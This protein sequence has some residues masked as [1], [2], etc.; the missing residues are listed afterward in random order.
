MDNSRRRTYLNKFIK[1][2]YLFFIICL[3]FFVYQ[4]IDLF[5]ELMSGKTVIN[6]SVGIIRNTTLPAITFCPGALDFSRMS[7]S[8]E[9]VSKLF[10][11]YLEMIEN[12]NR[13][14]IN[15]IQNNLDELYVK[16]LKIYFSSNGQKIQIKD[17]LNNLTPFFDKMNETILSTIF[18]QSSAYGQIDKDLIK[19]RREYYTYYL[20]KSLP[21]ESLLIA[22]TVNIPVT[23]KCYTL[24]SHSESSWDNIKMIFNRLKINLKLDPNSLPITPSLYIGLIMHSPNTLSIEGC[25]NVNP[26]YRYL[27]EYSKWKIKRL[28]KGYDTDCREYDPKLYT[29]NDCIFHCYQ[30]RAKYYC[31]TKDLVSFPMLKKKMYFEQRNLNLSKCNV[32]IEII[33]EILE[34]CYGQCNK[35][36]HITYYSFTISKLKEID[37]YQAH[38][39][40]KHNQMPDLTIR[41]IPEMPLLAYSFVTSVVYWECGLVFRLLIFLTVYGDYVSRFCPRHQR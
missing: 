37:K 5:I 24:F 28:G 33:H 9:N 13:S 27:I 22:L 30:Q 16:A 25:S 26:G 40:F 35:E 12:A 41:H 19:H 3:S 11:Q 36:C 15:D 4:S 29:R 32:K 39:E 18:F 21:M 6:I 8:N 20:M 1:I 31:R 34:L 10:K 23:I 17:I 38:F 2:D 14:R 7:L